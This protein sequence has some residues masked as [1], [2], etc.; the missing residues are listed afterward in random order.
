[1][2]NIETKVIE[3]DEQ[4]KTLF[5]NQ[6]RL[7]KVVDKINDLTVAIGKMTTI[8]QGLI[9]GQTKLKQDVEEIKTQPAKDA[10]ETKQKII[11]AI[12]TTTV[13]LVVGALITLIAI[14]IVKGGI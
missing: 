2:T 6:T 12:I 10:H 13:G 4:I 3:H 1:M 9:D 11:N 5:N 7:E 14:V 8:Q